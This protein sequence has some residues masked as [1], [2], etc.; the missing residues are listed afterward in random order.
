MA[1]RVEVGYLTTMP[2]K[3]IECEREVD[4]WDLSLI[5]ASNQIYFGNDSNTTQFLSFLSELYTAF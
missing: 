2:E 3:E 4:A 1:G 5:K